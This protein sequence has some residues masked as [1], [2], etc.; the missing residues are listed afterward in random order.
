VSGK[1]AGINS[2]FVGLGNGGVRRITGDI[3]GEEF[4]CSCD[5]Y[6]GGLW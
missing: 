1:E 4:C 5:L 3:V 2:L 6:L